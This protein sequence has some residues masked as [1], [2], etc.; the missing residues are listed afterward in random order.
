MALFAQ[1]P[2]AVDAGWRDIYV[3]SPA[4]RAMLRMEAVRKR[5]Q[6]DPETFSAWHGPL[7]GN[8]ALLWRWRQE[9]LRSCGR[10]H[11]G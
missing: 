7:T 5:F 10:D 2:T 3:A 8:T 11:R 4:L 9:A 1:L 6:I